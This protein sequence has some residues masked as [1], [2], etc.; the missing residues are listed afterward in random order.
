MFYY[1]FERGWPLI[2]PVIAFAG[3]TFGVDLPASPAPR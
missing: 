2:A 3:G 1:D